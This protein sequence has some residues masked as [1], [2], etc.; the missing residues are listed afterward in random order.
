MNMLIVYSMLPGEIAVLTCFDAEYTCLTKGIFLIIHS[1][2]QKM[3]EPT[4]DETN[5]PIRNMNTREV[6]KPRPANFRTS[7]KN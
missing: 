4:H 6:K 5:M 2:T 7:N 3:V 1:P